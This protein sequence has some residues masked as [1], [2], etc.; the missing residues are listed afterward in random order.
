M[1]YKLYVDAGDDFSSGFTELTNYDGVSST[2]TDNSLVTGKVY[3][4][5]YVANNAYGDSE[6]S[7]DLIA[8]FGATPP[9]PTAPTKDNL[10]SNQTSM[11]I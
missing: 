11:Y 8:G 1:E 10:L 4:F 7:H 3:R 5:V 6:Y 9:A 2:Y